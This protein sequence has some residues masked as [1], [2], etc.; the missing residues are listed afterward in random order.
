MLKEPRAKNVGGNLGENSSLFG[1]FAFSGGVHVVV[2]ARPIS[3]PYTCIG[4]VTSFWEIISTRWKRKTGSPASGV[5][6]GGPGLVVK[7]PGVIAGQRGRGPVFTLKI[8]KILA[9]NNCEKIYRVI[10][11]EFYVG[12]CPGVFVRVVCGIPSLSYAEVHMRVNGL[13][14]LR[15]GGRVFTPSWIIL[16]EFSVTR[17]RDPGT[18]GARLC[19]NDWIMVDPPRDRVSCSFLSNVPVK[20]QSYK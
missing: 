9:K 10:W 20:S 16:W 15:P 1:V 3:R 6:G 8:K 13:Y 7:G 14:R 2:E 19:D 12:F 18:W 4:G 11:D 5:T 17:E